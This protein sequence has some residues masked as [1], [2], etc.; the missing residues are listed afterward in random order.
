[1]ARVHVSSVARTTAFVRNRAIHCSNEVRVP[2]ARAGFGNMRPASAPAMAFY[3]ERFAMFGA[4]SLAV[5][6]FRIASGLGCVRDKRLAFN[7]G[8]WLG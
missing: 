6:V 8:L 7:R 1:M 5:V 4:D 2:S 3:D